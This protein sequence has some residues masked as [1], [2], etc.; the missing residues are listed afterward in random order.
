[1]WSANQ[2][3]DLRLGKSLWHRTSF[4]ICIY[5]AFAGSIKQWPIVSMLIC[6]RR[7]PPTAKN[8][9]NST[10]IGS[11]TEFC[12][13]GYKTRVYAINFHHWIKRIVEVGKWFEKD[14]HTLFP[15]SF[16]GYGLIDLHFRQVTDCSFLVVPC[17]SAQSFTCYIKRRWALPNNLFIAVRDA[18]KGSYSIWGQKDLKKIKRL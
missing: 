3:E 6:N 1:M 13:G 17:N 14:K 8:I 15:F 2:I 5:I 10:I 7:P 18:M 16:L 12:R 4:E 11:I 9:L